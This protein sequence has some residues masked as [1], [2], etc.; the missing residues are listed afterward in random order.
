[1]KLDVNAAKHHRY[2]VYSNGETLIGM[3][4]NKSFNIE[5]K[6]III[7]YTQCEYCHLFL[8]DVMYLLMDNITRE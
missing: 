8:S 3:W 7:H 2:F 4:N 1:M 6:S 5:R